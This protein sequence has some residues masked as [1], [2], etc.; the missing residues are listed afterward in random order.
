MLRPWYLFGGI[1]LVFL[2]L[3]VTAQEFSILGNF[4]ITEDNGRVFL[5]W[6]ILSGNTCDGTKIFRSKDGLSFTQ[7]GEI[8]GIC[9]SATTSEDY[10]FIDEE[11]AGNVINYYRLELGASGYSQTLSVDVVN[12]GESGYQLRPNPLSGTGKIF[13]EN[14]K[15]DQCHLTVCNISGAELFNTTTTDNFFRLSA[16]AIPNGCYIFLITGDGKQISGKIVVNK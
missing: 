12:I 14:K 15:H 4:S 10:S 7:I 11:P 1:L 2:S 13:F 6:S 16:A 3:K 8:S 5:S 9:G